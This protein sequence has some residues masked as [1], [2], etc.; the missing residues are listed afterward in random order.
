M[1]QVSKEQ[2]KAA[3]K[4]RKQGIA[5]FVKGQ[6]D[7]AIQQF[8]EAINLNPGDPFAYVNRAE[9]YNRQKLFDD[10]IKD[11][12][13]AINIDP[14]F[15]LACNAYKERGNAYLAKGQKKE[16]VSDLEQ[17]LKLY[18]KGF[19]SGDFKKAL[20]A[21]KA[22]P[23]QPMPQ[24]AKTLSKGQQSQNQFCDNCGQK[25]ESGAVFCDSCGAKC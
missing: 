12:T 3:E 10:A 6:M 24:V 25:L 13:Q 18:G 9:V 19:G 5:F 1:G 2:V 17:A 7:D 14:K 21:A 20:E 22:M 4:S 15:S 8:G 16:A 11:C 23:D